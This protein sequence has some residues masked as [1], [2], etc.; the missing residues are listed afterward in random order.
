MADLFAILFFL[1]LLV[2]LAL[3]LS[4]RRQHAQTGLPYGARIVYADT[5]AWKKV[6]RPLFS[7][8]YG[9]TGKPDYIVEE[10]GVTIPVEVK[11]NRVAPA[12]RESDAL[13]LAAYALLVKE[14]FGATPAYGLLKYRDAVFQIELTDELRA[15][16][17]DTLAALRRD[18]N[19][20]DVAR[21]HAEPR[22]CRAC[23]Y[24][25]ECGQSL[26]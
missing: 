22:R 1:T 10:R 5:G 4:A 15:R 24:R 7:R 13:Q 21:S 23:G 25:D 17:L 6:E 18:L 14:N 19:A 20:R 16:L 3:F 9:L 12:P 8:R 11:P 2:A 26:A